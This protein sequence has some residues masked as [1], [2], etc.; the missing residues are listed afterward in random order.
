MIS[1]FRFP[2]IVFIM[3][4]FAPWLLSASPSDT[5]KQWLKEGWRIQSSAKTKASGE[6]IA[7]KGFDAGSW[8]PAAIPSTVLAALVE[9]KVYPDPYF[10][11]NLRSIPGT[12][13]SIGQNFSNIPMPDDSPF[14]VS[15]WYRTEFSLSKNLRGKEIRLNFEGI[16]FRANLW[17][18]GKL[19]ADSKKVAGAWRLFEFNVTGNVKVGET[20]VLA[21]EVFPPT[22][23]DLA[24]TFVDWNPLPADKDMGI[25]RGVYVTS[26]GP[27][28][29]RY[30]A[31]VTHFA[32]SDLKTANL[33][34]YSEL[35][36]ALA[37][38]VKGTLKG[39]IEGKKF[40][41][42][43]SLSAGE[44]KE[45]EFS[46]EKF[47]Q[48]KF[49]NPRVWWPAP[50]G[51]QP[52]YT[53]KIEFDTGGKI[54]D[55][56]KVVFGIREA[57][58][59]L[60]AAQ[61]RVFM[62]NGKKILV[63]GAGW[64]FDM[65]LRAHPARQEAEIRY[66]KDMNLNAIRL[67]GKLEDEHFLEECDREGI[68]VLAGW[69]CCDHWERWEKWDDED[70]VV[71]AESL[72][73]QIRRLRSHACL[74]DWM[75]GSDNPPPPKVEEVYIKI[76]KDYHWPNPYHSS[77]TE[78]PTTVSGPSGVKMT[79][80]YEYVAPSYWLQ[81]SKRGGAY[82]FN[83]ETSPGPAIPPVES[84][85]QFLP[86]GSLWPINDD[87]DFHAGGG[88]FRTVQVFTKA[89]EGRYGTANSLHD[90]ERK[91]QAMA[92]EGERAMFEAYAR[93]KYTSTGVIQW[94]LNN[95]W[96]SVIWHL[97]DYYLRPAG[98]Y[99]GSKK[100]CEPL[101]I[102]YSYDDQSVGVVNSFYEAHKGLKAT[103]KIY[104]LDLEEKFSK[105]VDA[106]APPD[107]STR[108]L[109]LPA[110][111][112]LSN[113][114]FLKLTLE[115][116]AGK[117]VS[118]NL[119]WL[120]TQPDVSDWDK[121]QWYVTPIKTY[122]DLT[123][124]EKLPPVKVNVTSRSEHQGDNDVTQ[125]TV[126][127]PTSNLAFMVHLMITKGQGGDEVL[128]ILWE[129]NYFTLFPGEKRDLAARYSVESRGGAAPVV[130]VDGWNVTQ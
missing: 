20:N 106:D 94:M 116:S 37:K 121:S 122:A 32:S 39:E 24:I 43:V 35:H 125:V 5:P 4:A 128:P 127:N 111:D 68:L 11:K 10:G 36:N 102:Q 45:V 97:Y 109:T 33:T 63:R 42:E 62:I 104:N 113:T 52:L 54:S 14:R 61:H 67:E 6:Q 74:F 82:G 98:G 72:K 80:P 19:I 117:L 110:V 119:Y 81:D 65:L 78:R 115:D 93:N 13:Y 101:H 108:V 44:T 31:V 41:Q 23:N 38:P 16:N 22:P 15:W 7:S 26:S 57:T 70:Y 8:Y 126:E 3:L 2:L 34:V 90:Y 21:A 69:C 92:Y 96:P 30:P 53:L 99:F 59:E 86:E 85:K 49:E 64:S 71:S 40:S 114:Y 50:L 46:P 123:G 28:A 75:N 51:G 25:W 120:S 29:L 27:V 73:D 58:S 83:T 129:D 18:N 88:E 118:S 84:L 77:A 12:S 56:Q 47:E 60:D 105:T 89:L 103:A 1:R 17:L 55:E 100:A 124:L 48:L 95:A 130:V 91:A 76:L 87:W 9:N 66:V 107:S 79:G 112:G